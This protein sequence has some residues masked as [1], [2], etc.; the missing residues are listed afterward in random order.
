[1]VVCEFEDAL[2]IKFVWPNTNEILQKLASAVEGR[3][4]TTRPAYG[5]GQYFLHRDVI[6]VVSNVLHKPNVR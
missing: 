3:E 2:D 5:P 1:M 4:V 6:S